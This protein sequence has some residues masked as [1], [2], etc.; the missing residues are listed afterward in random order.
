[1]AACLKRFVQTNA[2]VFLLSLVLSIGPSSMC[3]SEASYV[4]E[5][6]D[7]GPIMIGATANTKGAHLATALSVLQSNNDSNAQILISNSKLGALS[8]G[9]S[10]VKQQ[11]TG[12]N[13]W[14][15]SIYPY[16]EYFNGTVM[17]QLKPSRPFFIAP[18]FY[19]KKWTAYERY[20]IRTFLKSISPP[21]KGLNTST[22]TVQNWWRITSKYYYDAE[23][24]SITKDVKIYGEYN[25]RNSSAPRGTKSTPLTRKDMK[26]I[27]I[28]AMK[29]RFGLPSNRILF[30]VLTDVDTYVE[31]FCTDLCTFH[32][33]FRYKDRNAVYLFVGNA[34]RQ[35]PFRCTFKYFTARYKPAND[36]GADGMI[37]WLAHG[38]TAVATN[39]LSGR[40]VKPGWIVRDTPI[41]NSDFC[42][43]DFG[44]LGFTKTYA[45]Y[46]TKGIFD[47]RFLIQRNWNRKLE[48]CVMTA[49]GKLDTPLPTTPT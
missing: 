37:N 12:N 32:T 18:I 8:S 43:L 20:V 11:I 28:N 4:E 44:Y 21:W 13:M 35:C 22:R 6:D 2:Y 23:G 40:R 27:V 3:F 19:G 16:L 1:M 14:T 15:Q 48:A 5:V 25:D 24:R 47:M 9:E 39:T 45:I 7:D 33:S 34:A 30:L 17:S 46:N 36:L 41:E 29:K 10:F 42:Q 38:L 49:S 26:N 31:N